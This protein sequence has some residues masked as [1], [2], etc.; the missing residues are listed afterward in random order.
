MS[1]WGNY[2]NNN[3][4]GNK[5]KVLIRVVAVSYLFSNFNF[6]TTSQLTLKL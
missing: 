1:S 2:V 3:K 5:A 4:Q 6:P